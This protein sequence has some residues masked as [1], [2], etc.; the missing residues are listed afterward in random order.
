MTGVCEKIDACLMPCFAL[1]MAKDVSVPL[2]FVCLLHLANEK[3]LRIVNDGDAL[4][5]LRISQ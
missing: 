5:D 1:Q 2:C 4:Q 3:G